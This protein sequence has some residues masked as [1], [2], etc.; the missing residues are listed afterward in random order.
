VAG[1]VTSGGVPI[2]G[3][4]IVVRAGDAVQLATSSDV[5][6]SYSIQFVPRA[7]YRVT[8][9]ATGFLETARD[10]T[11]AD[12]PCDQTVDY[13]IKLAPRNA[14]GEPPPA[15]TAPLAS[16]RTPDAA[17]TAPR[18]G[19]RG[20]AGRSQSSQAGS[21]FQTLNVQADANGIVAA[22]TQG[23]ESEDIARLLPAGF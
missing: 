12:P 8:V 2:P 1:R 10:L 19:G 13:E 15:S 20:A 3:A 16:S 6:G 5:E 4:S 18:G 11:L 21:R 17:A 23:Q 7:Q 14:A 9:D 22:E